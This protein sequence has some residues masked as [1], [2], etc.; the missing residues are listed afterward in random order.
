MTYDITLMK[1]QLAFVEATDPFIALVG[2]LGSG[3][4][5]AGVFRTLLLYI[6]YGKSH[7]DI[8][9]W[10]PTYSLLQT[11]VL[12]RFERLLTA[13][14]IAYHKKTTPHIEIVITGYAYKLILKSYEKTELL[15][16]FEL[17]H[18]IIDELDTLPYNK[19]EKVFTV[20]TART[21]KKVAGVVNTIAVVTTPDKG[22]Q[23]FTYDF[24]VAKHDESKKLIKAKT[25]DNVF[26]D[27]RYLEN[28]TKLFTKE[29]L[30]A[31]LNGEFVNFS[32]DKVYLN[33]SKESNVATLVTDTTYLHVGI[34]FN[35]GG[36]VATIGV[37]SKKRDSLHIIQQLSFYDTFA[38]IQYF[39]LYYGKSR[40][41][42]YPDAS[43]QHRSTNSSVT[44][45]S[46]LKDAGFLVL[47]PSKNPF[48][49]D[50]I[51]AVNLAF[52]TKKVTISP[53]VTLCI[54]ALDTQIYDQNGAPEKQDTHPSIDDRND[55][56]GYMV[57]Y[58]FNPTQKIAQIRSS[59][60]N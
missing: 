21:R 60:V 37:L 4:S 38:F 27:K 50:R 13:M 7:G 59:Y 54:T 12:P 55:S 34:D 32:A 3:K 49:R 25:S 46:M 19:A 1:H 11:V 6:K 51:N 30:E 43:G 15:I 26:L 10:L 36:T 48:V 28:L 41:T 47:Y 45:V 35:I 5:D 2:G 14:R 20:G 53:A 58:L 52:Y 8:G 44:N 17:I 31:M 39:K 24:F 23:G 29:Q 57:H 16:G 56:L 42:I 9:Y 18:L 40:I 22:T 33:F